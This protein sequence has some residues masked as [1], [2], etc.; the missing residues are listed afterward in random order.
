GQV[1]VKDN[2][3]APVR[4]AIKNPTDHKKDNTVVATFKGGEMSVARFLAWLDV[5]PAQTRQQVMQV[6]PTWPDSSVK[7][8]ARNMALRELLL[9]KAD[10][11]KVDIPPDQKANLTLEFNNLVQKE[12]SDLGITPKQL[13]DSAK[14]EKDREKLA[15]ARVDTLLKR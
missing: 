10:S 4:E 8:F 5:M 1:T 2:A 13:A 12:W 7:A 14:S 6:V 15:A 11:A 9:K 3:A